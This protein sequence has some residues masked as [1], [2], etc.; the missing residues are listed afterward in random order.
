[1][2]IKLI[3]FMA[4]IIVSSVS[5]V[6]ASDLSNDYEFDNNTKD[7]ADSLTPNHHSLHH[8]HYDENAKNDFTIDGY[9]LRFT[10]NQ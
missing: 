8:S 6:V 5:I 10:Q 2:N 9:L 1:M 4:I 3:I 7:D